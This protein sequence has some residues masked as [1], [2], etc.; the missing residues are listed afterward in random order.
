MYT[1][2]P[3]PRLTLILTFWTLRKHLTLCALNWLIDRMAE[4]VIFQECFLNRW[5]PPSCLRTTP[6]NLLDKT[7]LDLFFMCQLI[8]HREK[9]LGIFVYAKAVYHICKPTPTN[10]VH[11]SEELNMCH[12]TRGWPSF[13]LL[14]NQYPNYTSTNFCK[15]QTS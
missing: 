9:R 14:I 2:P 15:F 12:R 8:F 7:G 4:V 13:H 10:W 3:P 1:I 11:I 5:T 6:A